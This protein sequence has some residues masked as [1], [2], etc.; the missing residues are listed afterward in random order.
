LEVGNSD[1][2]TGERAHTDAVPG[3]KD[4]GL[5]EIAELQAG[6]VTNRQLRDGGMSAKDIKV[7]LRRG[8]LRATSARGVYRVAGA[9]RTWRQDLWI[10]LLAGPDGTLASHVSAAALRGLIAPPS[11]PHVTVPRDGSGR[12]RGAVVHHATVSDA[13]RSQFEDI[14]TTAV[15]R[16]L[17]DCAAVLTQT[18]LNELVDAAFGRGFCGYEAT[19]QAWERAGHVRGGARLEAALA[20]YATGTQPGSVGAAHVLRKICDW[21]LPLPLCEYEIRDEHGEWVATVDFAWPAW[22]FVLEYDG[23]AA[24]GPRRW[25]LD[26]RRQAA[27]ER[28]GWRLERA[29]RFDARPSSTRLFDLLAP[30][31][32]QAPPGG[33]V[34]HLPQPTRRKPSRR[35]S[36]R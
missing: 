10:A 22:W 8:S 4:D 19:R 35:S 36:A 5:A 3:T 30:I 25:R 16:T 29:D 24:H 17:V 34:I 27:I 11:I 1:A 21:G 15:G 18:G 7:R 26:A 32:T 23:R 13:D 20:P 6:A 2:Y 12:F 9:E 31:L 33:N 14:T 28:I